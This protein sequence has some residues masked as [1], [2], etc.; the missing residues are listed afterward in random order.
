MANV[1]KMTKRDNY[2]T[3]LTL[4][5]DAQSE[6][7][8]TNGDGEYERLVEFINHEIEQLNKRA[9][10][11][12]KY[13]KKAAKANDALADA[14]VDTLHST[15]VVMNIGEIVAALP[16]DLGATNQKVVYRLNKLV[17]S[18]VVFKETTTI[19]EEKGSRKVN[20]YS[21]NHDAETEE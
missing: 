21:W 14:I 15:Q 20:V 6:G 9:A 2:E 16:E 10:S 7:Y 18:G 4:V 12:K 5:N 19:K 8:F 11:A 3:L 17:E 13:A 1:E